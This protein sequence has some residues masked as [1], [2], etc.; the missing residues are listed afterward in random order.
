M[1]PKATQNLVLMWDLFLIVEIK[2]VR[3][4]TR[5][6]FLKYAVLYTHAVSQLSNPTLYHSSS[7]KQ[8]KPFKVPD[9]ELQKLFLSC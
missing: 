2:T 1:W 8:T 4:A 9:I 7:N 3:D 5:K 6:T